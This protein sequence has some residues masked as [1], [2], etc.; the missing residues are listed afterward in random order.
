MR[1]PVPLGG[2][3]GFPS[4]GALAEQV[5]VG[6]GELVADLR[7]AVE[8]AGRGRAKGAKARGR[9]AQCGG[10]LARDAEARI[11]DMS[12]LAAAAASAVGVPGGAVPL[13]SA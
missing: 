7:R 10:N 6:Q 11:E 5:A 3:A 12:R 13:Q 4:G 1:A 9:E 8:L 2:Q